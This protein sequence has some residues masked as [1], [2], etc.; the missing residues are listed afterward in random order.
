MSQID[1]IRL[2]CQNGS[3]IAEIARDLGYDR[4]T[5]RKYLQEKDFTEVM[6]IKIARPSKLDPYKDTINT[7]L[8]EDRKTWH[9]QR[10]TA[11]K[12]YDRLKD[13]TDYEGSYPTVQRYIKALKEKRREGAAY[14]ELHWYPGESQ[15]DFGEADFLVQG[16]LERLYYLVLS[17]PHSNHS[18]VQLFRGETAE[19]VCEGLLSMFYYMGAIPQVIIFDNASGV[20]QRIEAIVRESALF[21]RFRMHHGFEVRFC[22]PNSG[23]EKGNVENK[24]G[25]I[26]RNFFVPVRELDDLTVFNEKFLSE[27]ESQQEKE[28]YKKLILVGDLFKEDLAAMRDLPDFRF[29][30]IRYETKRSDGYGKICLEGKHYY[31]SR[32]ELGRQEITVGIRAHVVEL[33]DS[34]GEHV[35]THERRYGDQR[36]DTTD[37][38]TTLLQLVRAPNAWRNS[39]LREALPGEV[40]ER[41]DVLDTPLL[42]RALRVLWQ[43]SERHSQEV[44]LKALMRSLDEGIGGYAEACLYAAQVME[45]EIGPVSPPQEV[46]LGIYDRFL[47]DTK[48]GV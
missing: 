15:A 38:Y 13:E 19:C 35:V 44:S 30:V 25:F 12:I 11:T 27:C 41:L 42:Q 8:E 47:L 31:S 48:V 1:S 21:R 45:S 24:V 26:R 43:L 18:Y 29:D 37:H 9:K 14:L 4:K 3:S 6:P 34:I 7:W 40:R 28:H 5:V 2:A 17:F 33:Y 10:H 22:N 23:H 46:D 32:P 36:T 20:G 39:G 16:R